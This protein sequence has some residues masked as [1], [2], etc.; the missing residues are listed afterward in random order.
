MVSDRVS[1]VVGD[2]LWLE[3]V[4]RADAGWVL[5]IV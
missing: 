1:I 3:D 5:D 2:V 4:E